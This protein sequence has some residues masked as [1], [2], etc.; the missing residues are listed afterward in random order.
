MDTK[1]V[2]KQLLKIAENQQKIIEKL[3]Q[4]LPGGGDVVLGPEHSGAPQTAP[5][6][7]TDLKPAPITKNTAAIIIEALG[8]FYK[9]NVEFLEVR[10]SDVL[11]RFLS[12][13]S[14]QPNYNHILNVVK[15]LQSSNQLQGFAYNVK[16]V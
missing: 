15:K 9:Q 11:V 5:P 10:G 7:P 12:G 6:P 2:I 8:D 1:K 14:T 16:V 13:K 4:Q 3:A